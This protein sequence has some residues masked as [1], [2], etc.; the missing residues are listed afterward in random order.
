MASR[1]VGRRELGRL[2]LLW[3]IAG[4]L[5]ALGGETPDFTGVWKL[6]STRPRY[7]ETWTVKQSAADIHIRMNITDDQLGDRILDFECGL[8]G[9]ECK[10][11]VIGTPTTVSAVWDGAALMLEITRQARPDLLLHNRR[12]LRLAGGGKRIESHHPAFAVAPR[13]ARGGL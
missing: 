1:K 13:R 10:Q 6:R 3:A 7:S 11:T 5:A 2:L 8:D 4:M 9:K 12:L